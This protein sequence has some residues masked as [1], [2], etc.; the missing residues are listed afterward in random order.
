METFSGRKFWP[1]DPRS[2][3]VHPGDIAHALGHLCRFN[4]HVEP[5]YS[6]AEHSL[7]ACELLPNY[8][9][10]ALLH[11]AAEAYIG[12]IIRPL[13]RFVH[14][15]VPDVGQAFETIKLV[16][17]RVHR[18]IA[19]R[20]KLNVFPAAVLA[21]RAVDSA[22]LVAEAE[23][24]GFQTRDEWDVDA[25]PFLTMRAL[26]LLQRGKLPPAG[27][28]QATSMMLMKMEALGLL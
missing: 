27:P 13:K 12:D 14:V 11:D 25:D 2:E 6:V 7:I 8:A 24:F 10:E 23:L 21:V 18:A 20:F 9:K 4:G 3:E 15:G 17:A 1:L 16:E 28:H 19:E 5:F 22:L 26:E